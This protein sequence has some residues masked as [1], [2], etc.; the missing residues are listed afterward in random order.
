MK[1]GKAVVRVGGIGSVCTDP[2]SRGSGIM[3]EMLNQAKG[4]LDREFDISWLSGDRFRYRNY[5]WELGGRQRVFTIL[6]RDLDRY[7]PDVPGAQPRGIF[8]ADIPLLMRLYRKQGVGAVRSR[9]DFEAR[10]RRGMFKWFVVDGRSEN[11]YVAVKADSLGEMVEV[12]GDDEGIVRLMRFLMSRNSL[13]SLQVFAPD[14]VDG[15][16]ALLHHV[17]CS[18]VLHACS[19]IRTSNVSSCWEKLCPEMIARFY[20]EDPAGAAELFGR[21]TNDASRTLVLSRA[22]GFLDDTPALPRSLRAFERMRP[23]RWYLSNVDGV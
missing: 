5:G 14:S 19:Q 23:L 9:S 18:H 21:L 6:K 7:C 20:S 16:G 1:I 8:P 13:D 11:A 12:V 4:I 3:S 2:A 17:C 22:L 10:L 15:S